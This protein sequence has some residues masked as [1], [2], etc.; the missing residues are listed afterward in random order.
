MPAVPRQ[1]TPLTADETA[2]LFLEAWG[3]RP[4]TQVQAEYLLGLIWNENRKGAAIQNFNWGN[5]SV[6][7]KSSDNFWRPPWFDSDEIAALPDGARKTNLEEKH[8]LMLNGQAPR[9]F[10]A[11]ESH[12]EGARAWVDALERRFPDIPRAAATGNATRFANAV[13]DSG[14]CKA[15]RGLAKSYQSLA[16]EVQQHNYFPGLPPGLNGG[17]KHGGGFVL[18]AALAIGGLAWIASNHR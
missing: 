17:T 8:E 1:N 3:D 4:L 13:A 7:D 14:Y 11:F 2:P 5:L 12:D 6:S 18:I 15:C 9:A 10:R 16:R